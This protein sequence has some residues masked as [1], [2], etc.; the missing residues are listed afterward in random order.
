MP[1]DP[2]YLSA[3]QRYAMWE[4]VYLL[5]PT[6]RDRDPA[7]PVPCCGIVSHIDDGEAAEMLLGLDER[8]V[9]E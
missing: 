3:A 1:R 9:G 6:D 7:S 4:S 5:W 2:R 8:S